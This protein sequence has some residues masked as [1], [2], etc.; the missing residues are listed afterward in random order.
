MKL[1]GGVPV[2]LGVVLALSCS[3]ALKQPE[4]LSDGGCGG[5]AKD[6]CGRAKGLV[7]AAT[8]FSNVK[9]D[10]ILDPTSSFAP[11]RGLEQV[12]GGLWNVLPTACAK[13]QSDAS[14]SHLDAQ[15]IDFGFV[16]VSI[17]S[18]LVGA[19]VDLTPYLS[20]GAQAG[21]HHVKLVAVAF[22]RDNDPQFFDASE[23]VSLSGQACACRT[24]THFVGSVKMGGML[25]YDTTVREG[26]VHA[27][28]LQYIKAKLAAKDA[29][30]TETR[31]GGLEVDG[32]DDDPKAGAAGVKPLTFRVKNPVPVAYAAYPIGDVCK[33]GFPAPDV[34]PAMVD[35][36]ETPYGKEA[37]H[38][39]HVVNRAPFD[40]HATIGKRDLDIGARGS[41]DVPISWMPLGETAGCE[42]QQ[43]DET[44]VFAP[45]STGAPVM[46][47]QQSV[48]LALTVRT[49]K[50][51]VVRAEH[52][53][54]GEKRS[55]DYAATK[56]DWTCPPDYTVAACHT[57][58]ESCG[59]G[60][61]CGGDGYVITAD[62]KG[63]G[64]SF[65][66]Q[67][68]TSLLTA[69]N[70]CRF[71]AV[72]ECKLACGSAQKQA[73]PQKTTAP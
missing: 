48:K 38:L 10:Y 34:S 16:G 45:K 41:A 72:M 30:V 69:S 44:I 56:R 19:D 5:L 52:V 14:A 27:T 9:H 70:Y 36:G 61:G 25:A 50:D 39:V 33:F 68:P 58:S 7:A 73:D 12:S 40:V 11:G 15:T 8:T 26:D 17:D 2:A 6:A 46:P 32:L 18:T 53:D 51:K 21:V 66:C 60:V 4:V 55:P 23:E 59:S 3:P 49:G 54:T 64:C 65:G 29:V 28:A 24:A 62:T 67:G 22:V 37:T 35:F 42:A 63:N 31:V 1:A 71:D 57:Q 47:Q 43:R 20:L 13:P